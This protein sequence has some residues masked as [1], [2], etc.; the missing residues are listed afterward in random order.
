[1]SEQMASQISAMKEQIMAQEVAKMAKDSESDSLKQR[2]TRLT[3]LIIHQT[4]D[5][6]AHTRISARSIGSS[7]D[8]SQ[9]VDDIVVNGLKSCTYPGFVGQ[10]AGGRG[11]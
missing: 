5:M 8:M 11:L 3:R 9:S 10:S 2:I 4:S 1:M 6:H 7:G